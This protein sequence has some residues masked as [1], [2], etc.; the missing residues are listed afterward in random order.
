MGLLPDIWMFLRDFLKMSLLF[1]VF[2]SNL[3]SHEKKEDTIL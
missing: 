3:H 2:Q 1:E